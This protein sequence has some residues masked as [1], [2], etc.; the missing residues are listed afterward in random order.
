M[1]YLVEGFEFD[2]DKGKRQTADGKVFIYS[3][4]GDFIA[5]RSE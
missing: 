4:D 5:Y 1:K 3:K 2:T